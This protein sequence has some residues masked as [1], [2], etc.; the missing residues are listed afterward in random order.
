[1]GITFDQLVGLL[2]PDAAQ[3]IAVAGSALGTAPVTSL[4][5]SCLT[6]GTLTLSDAVMTSDATAQTVTVSG[7]VA[8]GTFLNA[9]TATVTDG[10]FALDED[11]SV[12]VTLPIAVTDAAWGLPSAFPTLD[13]LIFDS[14]AWAGPIFTLTVPADPTLPADFRPT[15][16]LGDDLPAVAGAIVPGLILSSGVAM[17][18]SGV[19]GTIATLL[20]L[21]S[22]SFCGPLDLLLLPYGSADTPAPFPQGELTTTTDAQPITV[23]GYDLTFSLS[24]ASVFVEV[25]DEKSPLSEIGVYCLGA[26]VLGAQFTP[27]GTGIQA[28][29]ITTAVI[30]GNSTSLVFRATGLPTQTCNADDLSGILA[31]TSVTSTLSPGSGFDVTDGLTIE[32]V[33]LILDISQPIPAFSSISVTVSLGSGQSWTAFGMLTFES[34]EIEV[35]VTDMGDGF[36]PDGEASCTAYLTDNPDIALSAFVTFPDLRFGVALEI[37]ETTQSLDLTS[38]VTGLIGDHSTSTEDGGSGL[39]SFTA[40]AF[41]M[42]GNVTRNQYAFAADIKESWTLVGSLVL[43][44]ISLS[45]AYDGSSGTVT[46]GIAAVLSLPKMEVLVSANYDPSGW[47]FAGSGLS[48]P[49]QPLTLSD[50]LDYV[51]GLFDLPPLTGLPEVDIDEVSVEYRF[52]AGA[53]SVTATVSFPS[54]TVNL[55]ALPLVGDLVGPDFQLSLQSVTFTADTAPQTGTTPATSNCSLSLVVGLGTSETQ[56]I[57]IPL[58][59]TQQQPAGTALLVGEATGGTAPPNGTWIDV[60]RSFGPVLVQKVGFGL[61]SQG[62]SVQMDASLTLSGLDIAVQGLGVAIPLATPIEPTF[63]IDGL[64]VSYASPAVTISGSLLKTDTDDVDTFAGSL[65]VKAESLSL[66]AFGSYTAS[67]PPSMFAYLVLN[68][69]LGGPPIFFV[70]GLAAGFGVN[71]RLVPPPITGV[72]TFPLVA[73]AASTS[74]FGPQP[75]LATVAQKMST[76]IVASTGEYWIAAGVAFTSYEL[77]QSFALVTVEFGTEF[78]VALLGESTLAVPQDSKPYVFA[79]MVLEALYTPSQ[80]VFSVAAQLNSA[81]YVLDPNCHLTGGFA[82][83]IWFDPSPYAGDFVITLGGYNPS[84]KK[85]DHYPTVPRL[86]INWQVTTALSIQGGEYM[87]LTPAMIMVGGYLNAVWHSDSIKAWFSLYADFLIQWAP[88][89]YQIDAGVDFGVQATINLDI[90]TVTINISVGADLM[91]VGPPFSGYADI[92]LSVLSFRITFGETPPPP[93]L[94]WSQFKTQFLPSASAQQSPIAADA[95]DTAPVVTLAIQSGLLIDLTNATDGNGNAFPVDYVV[96]P[97]LLRFGLKTMIPIDTLTYNGTAVTGDWNTDIAIGP[98]G[99]TSFDNALD[100]VV[101]YEEADYTA[102]SLDTSGTGGAAAALWGPASNGQT[103]NGDAL[104]ADSL[105]AVGIVP[106]LVPPGTVQ[107]IEIATLLDTVEATYGLDWSADNAPTSDPFKG[108]DSLTA[109]ADTIADPG[110]V[111]ARMAIV[112]GL[113]FADVEIASPIDVSPLT[114]SATLGYITPIALSLLGAAAPAAQPAV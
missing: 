69:P 5:Q 2:T 88:L 72:A 111:A 108:E 26:V 43:E 54:A 90:T 77:V 68:E 96:D 106:S 19:L 52:P 113:L 57:T 47:T 99:L 83:Y 32:D 27:S 31:G 102:A 105:Q 41:E 7:T 64:A 10:V 56:I 9:A 86:G 6:G 45:L 107:A 8:T 59:G 79:Q 103:L 100:V 62:L 78:Q 53:L 65:I 97:H 3:T 75:S 85:P 73:G 22:G 13:G 101:E 61:G 81:S 71:T 21:S 11:G 60:E 50:L 4:F 15:L 110:V 70:T 46:G 114:A 35:G 12:S 67:S 89:A 17:P 34:I 112:S 42:T 49:D 82:F 24:F 92:H 94:D 38:T 29:Q 66:S 51:L 25:G 104:V 74:E 20:G 80:G 76:A 93:S 98:L 63:V 48:N 37:T 84:F 23:S 18:G 14:I 36:T 55:A 28:F 95:A 58:S 33:V 1:M 44:Q 39:T 91:I 109:L 40:L 16:G 30:S 87:A